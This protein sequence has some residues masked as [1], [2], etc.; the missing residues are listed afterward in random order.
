MRALLVTKLRDGYT[1]T[2]KQQNIVQYVLVRRLGSGGIPG[3]CQRAGY[4]STYKPYEQTRK[5]AGREKEKEHASHREVG[6]CVVGETLTGS[7]SSPRCHVMAAFIYS[8]ARHTYRV[9]PG[10]FYA[11]DTESSLL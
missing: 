4:E 5:T 7:A 11:R 9:P 2:C 10:R 8:L 6:A 3:I 1:H